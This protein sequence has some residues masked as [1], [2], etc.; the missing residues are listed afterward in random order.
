M[1]ALFVGNCFVFRECQ[2]DLKFEFESSM[3]WKFELVL[4]RLKPS[5]VRRI[6]ANQKQTHASLII[7][8]LTTKA[9]FVSSS[10][11]QSFP[12]NNYF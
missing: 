12:F 2:L 3:G 4:I 6:L 11:D 8:G 1:L 5:G 9:L 10:T 7:V